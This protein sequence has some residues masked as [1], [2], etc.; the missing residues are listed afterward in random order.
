[1]MP[2]SHG[3]C[4]E[5]ADKVISQT[6]GA[7]GEFLECLGAPVFLVDDDA[8]ILAA[9]RRG[10]EYVGKPLSAI[11]N[12]LCGDAM[13]CVNADL[14]GGCGKTESCAACAIRNSVTHTLATGTDLKGVAVVQEKKTTRGVRAV[15]FRV[16][17][18]KIGPFVFLQVDRRTN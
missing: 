12:Q 8:R 16:S 18:E 14:P 17:T 11:R 2:V 10:R 6:S 4:K 9:N 7:V 5:C 1:M 15:P 3:M 13:D